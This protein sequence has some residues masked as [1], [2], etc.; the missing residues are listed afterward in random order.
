MSAAALFTRILAVLTMALAPASAMALP[1]MAATGSAL[2]TIANAAPIQPFRLAP[3]AGRYLVATESLTDP[4]FRRSVI[5]I[6]SHDADGTLGVIINR[7]GRISATSL[8][9]GFRD[10]RL[11]FGGPVEPRKLSMLFHDP[12]LMSGT[13]ADAADED[14]APPMLTVRNDLGFVLGRHAVTEIHGRL[15]PSSPRRI[16]AGYAGWSPGQL[17]A[18]LE[19]GSWYLIED[20]PALAFADEDPAL[21]W[22]RL[23]RR[24]QGSW[25]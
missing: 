7:P 8:G 4:R 21:L 13:Q 17:D 5:M 25:I 14:A 16:Y 19:R 3:A 12:A 1:D 20:D 18:E 2:P 15:A 23:I 22:T 11:R 24:M 6:V 10:D 9:E